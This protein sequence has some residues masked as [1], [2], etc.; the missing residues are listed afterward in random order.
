MMYDLLSSFLFLC[1]V[2][3]APST[4]PQTKAV[5]F[6]DNFD[7]PPNPNPALPVA[8]PVKGT[9]GGTL[10][11]NAFSYADHSTT[12]LTFKV[13]SY[14]YCIG[15]GITA[16]LQQ[17]QRSIRTM[18]ASIPYFDPTKIFYACQIYDAT[19]NPSIATP[20]TIKFTGFKYGS[21]A[22]VVEKLVYD[23]SLLPLGQTFS[24]KMFSWGF[25]GLS[26][27]DI[28]LANSELDP[29]LVVVDLDSFGYT[30]YIKV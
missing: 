4:S 12:N 21:S 7:N 17:G 11:Y 5:K 2:T 1:F 27:I 25:A 3:A 9:A 15:S 14:P 18:N 26:K 13:P 6:F 8:S 29:N 10:Y 20:C 23:P 24:S 19:G 30:A 22:P 28:D 16:Q